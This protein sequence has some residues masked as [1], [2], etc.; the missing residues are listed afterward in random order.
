MELPFCSVLIQFREIL[1]EGW[2]T[3]MF[4]LRPRRHQPMVMQDAIST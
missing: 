4:W 1:A 3:P 2:D